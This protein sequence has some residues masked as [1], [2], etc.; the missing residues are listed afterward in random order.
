MTSYTS[1]PVPKIALL[2]S[3]CQLRQI[4]WND[5]FFFIHSSKKW[6]EVQKVKSIH[7]L[8]SWLSLIDIS[9]ED[10]SECRQEKKKVIKSILSLWKRGMVKLWPNLA[11][12]SI[13]YISFSYSRKTRIWISKLI[14]RYLNRQSWYLFYSWHLNFWICRLV[15]W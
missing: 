13:H 14:V 15:N 5:S 4:K 10:F 8:N 9:T 7:P 11:C 3:L 2:H 12:Q 6:A 1:C